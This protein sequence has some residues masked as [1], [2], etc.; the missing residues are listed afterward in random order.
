MKHQSPIRLAAVLSMAALFSLNASEAVAS[1]IASFESGGKTIRADFYPP[2]AER[3]THRTILAL[4]GAGGMLFDGPEMRRV[5]TRLALD[6]N[7]VYVVHYFNR[8]GSFFFAG[9][10]GM[11]KNFDTWLVTIRDAVKWAAQEQAKRGDGSQPIGI[12]GYSLGAFL[13]L[14]AASDNPSVEAVV[15]QAGGVWNNQERRIGHLPPTLLIHGRA[16]QRVAFEKYEEPLMKLLRR[17]G[18]K[19]E[20]RYYDDEGHGFSPAAQARA[21]EQVSDFFRRKLPRERAAE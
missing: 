3:N 19:F 4:H 5:A 21:R 18:T 17:R 9:D 16:D 14:A 11:Q 8:T 1:D 2:A 15:E 13:A 7:A 12:Y 6:G 10:S 20:T